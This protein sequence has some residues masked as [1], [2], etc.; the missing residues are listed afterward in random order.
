MSEGFQL[1]KIDGDITEPATVLINKISD[2]I[3]G[4]FKPRQIRRVADAEADADIIKAKSQVKVI[5]LERRALTRFIYEEAKKQENIESI[6]EK[7]IPE[8][9]DTSNPQDMDNDW[10]M[11]FFDKCRIVSDTD[12]QLLWSKVLAGEANNPGS[13]SKRTVNLLGSF[14]QSD[15]LLFTSLCRFSFNIGRLNPLIFDENALIYSEKNI[16]FGNLTHLDDIGLI[17]FNHLSG[18]SLT[19]LKQEI[20]ISYMGTILKL[21]FN[22]P[23]NNT[24][25]IGKVLPTKSGLELAQICNPTPVDG[26][27]DYSI[28][29]ISSQGITCII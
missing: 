7:A 19:D 14:S 2:A 26:F 17:T 22:K 10:I 29:N 11:N 21:K 1:I 27:F 13:Y 12:M 18:Y 25:Q 20:K 15:A 4:Y 28:K 3:G 16:N 6:T 23:E 9:V 24:L 8:L 5:E